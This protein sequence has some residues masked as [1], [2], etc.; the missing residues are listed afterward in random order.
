MSKA[1]HLVEAIKFEHTIFALPFAYIAMVLAADGWPGGWTALWVTL[2]MVGGRTCAMASNRVI[3]RWIDARNPRTAG[4]HLPTGRL[5]VWELRALAAAGAGLM[6]VAAA[7]LNTLCLALAPLALV[8]LV[9]YSYTKRFT[10]ASHWI[11]GF[12]DGIAAA[13][14]WIAVRDRFDAPALVLWLAVTVWIAGFDLIYA[15]QDVGVDRAQR[16]Q[17]VPA[18]F[19]IPLALTVAQVNHLLTAGALALLGAMMGLGALYWFGWLAVV[20]LLVYE[21]S[22]VRPDDLSRLDVAFFNV[23]GYIAVI[24]LVAVV[25]GLWRR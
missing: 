15:C 11:L 6:L 4:R 10:W 14:G 16:L 1:A 18:R 25:G 12:T 22:L 24:V 8:F 23:N 20:A 21:H 13:G 5:G 3:D 9:G 2:A 7:M 17:S 19:G